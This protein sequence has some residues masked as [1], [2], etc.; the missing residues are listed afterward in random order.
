MRRA[1]CVSLVLCLAS[2][3]A[4]S[5]ASADPSVERRL[6]AADV[7]Y[8]IDKDGDYRIAYE[9]TDENRSQLV[10]VSGRTESVGPFVVREVFAPAAHVKED[11]VDGARALDLLEESGR[12][13][14]GGWELRG[15]T[16]YFVIK[17]PDTVDATALRGAIDIAAEMADEMEIKLSGT[18][19]AY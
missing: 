5:D 17:L 2:A 18:K 3:M 19:D 8:E 7:N 6:K 15:T 14:L 16:L 13:K 1:T 12:I 10:F 4:V 11:R 9:Y